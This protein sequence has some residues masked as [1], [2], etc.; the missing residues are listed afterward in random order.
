MPLISIL[1]WILQLALIIH[2]VKTGRSF[3]WIMILLFMPLI[4]GLAYFVI[5]L[6][7]QFSGSITGQ[8]AVRSVKQTLNPGAD[9]RQNEAAWN[10]SPNVDNSRRYAEA[11]LDSGKTGEAEETINQALKGLFATEP[12]L[13][14]LRARLEFE[15]ERTIETVKTLETLQEH[16]PDFRSAE[17]HLLYARALEAE[18]RIDEAIKEYSAVS[19][20]FPG[21]EA[22]YRLALCLGVAG[23]DSAATTEF[24]SILNDAKLAPPHFRKSQKIWLDAVRN[25]TTSKG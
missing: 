6:L 2:V 12:T 1:V 10:Q 22:R 24:E 4:G 8:K 5:E 14:L 3:Y 9:L 18:G 19:G 23:K 25:E 15:N 16:N 17:G 21:V 20:Y 11:L 7:P 13:L